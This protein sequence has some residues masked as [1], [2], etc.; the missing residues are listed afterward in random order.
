WGAR[1]LGER[2]GARI[3]E[4][5]PVTVRVRV[6]PEAELLLLRPSELAHVDGVPLAARGDVS[7]VYEVETP[8]RGKPPVGDRLRMLAVFSL[9]T[10]STALGL[11]R[12]RYELGRLIR[13]LA[14]DQ[15]DLES[16]RALVGDQAWLPGSVADLAARVEQVEG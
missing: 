6:P 12:E 13:H 11:R 16:V 5:A 10:E 9:P 3:V 8:A 15:G 1:V 4:R 14:G 7:L 2:V